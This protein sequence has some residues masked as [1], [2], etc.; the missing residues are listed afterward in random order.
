MPNSRTSLVTVLAILALPLIGGCVAVL[1]GGAAT[2]GYYLAKD[3]RSAAQIAADGTITAT[4]K[5][6]LIADRYVKAFDV[7]VDT[8]GSV[9]TLTGEVTTYV[10]RDQAGM[11]AAEVSGVTKVRNEIRVVPGS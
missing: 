10:A 11:L 9:V 3:D 7:N 1:V 5:T 8:H 2:G 4:V 6:K